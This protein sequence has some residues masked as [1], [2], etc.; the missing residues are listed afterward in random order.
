LLSHHVLTIAVEDYFHVAALRGAVR[1]AHWS[2]LEPRL[3]RNLDA[4][5]ALLAR[6]SARATFFVFGRIAETQPELVRRIAEAGHEVASRGY[7]PRATAGMSRAEFLEDLH[8]ARRALEAAGANRILGFRSPTWIGTG[9]LWKLDVL[10][11][12][13]YLYDASINPR[14]W[15]FAG[16]PE[17]DGVYAHRRRAL[18][19]WEF[20]VS[21]VGPRWLRLPI[22]GGNYIRQIPH[23][24][25]KPLIAQA[26][27]RTTTPLVF[28]F[29]PWE[30]DSDQP[31]I[32]G[33]SALQRLRHYRNLGTAR[34]LIEDYLG[35]HRFVGIADHLALAHP[36][37]EPTTQLSSNGS[38]PS[39]LASG[40]PVTLV[41]PIYN[42]E[43]NVAYLR[44]TLKE[45]RAR[46]AGKYRVHLLLVDDGSTD[47]TREALQREFGGA[48]D[49]RIVLHDENRGVAAAI[50]TGIREAQTE[51][52]CSIDCDCSYDPAVLESMLPLASTADL[53]TAS[54]Y[55]PQGRVRNV[56]GWRL[57][58]SKSLSRLYS[59]VL[60]ER[61]FTYTSCCRVYR[62]SR[63]L[64]LEL[65]NGGF[66][67]TAEM[68]IRLKVSGGRIAEVPATLE[69]R[70]L[71]ESKMKIVRTIGGHLGL[72]ARLVR[73]RMSS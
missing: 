38:H 56:P 55:H 14:L 8:R 16:H 72:L 41:I 63:M 36:P 27:R 17:C 68:L 37:L 42:E 10:A 48:S 1:D 30:L 32:Q 23:A 50:M 29:M 3:E 28:Y 22:S 35:R 57:F 6:F 54:P 46:L 44:R 71:G 53:V 18:T 4:T 51:L 26:T 66:L 70:L 11:E 43:K 60:R 59:T 31:H 9:E 5:L 19:L 34:G 2:R 49:C 21:T 45:F 24:L 15:S 52:V 7:W 73:G 33:I 47:G 12:E 67:G 58:L 40:E 25:L 13:G 61:I 69:S 64:G 62:R 65:S 39:L 20:P